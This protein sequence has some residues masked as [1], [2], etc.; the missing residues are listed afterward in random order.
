MTDQRESHIPPSIRIYEHTHITYKRPFASSLNQVL[1]VHCKAL[2]TV[3]YSGSNGLS[4][5]GGLGV[6]TCPPSL[7]DGRSV[8]QFPVYQ[9]EDSEGVYAVR[10]YRGEVEVVID[11]HQGDVKLGDLK[12]A[13]GLVGG[14]LQ[15]L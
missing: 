9:G 11:L 12:D 14:W 2:F 5:S 15:L 3:I 6:G 8:V 13:G 4:S 10:S 1:H 7:P